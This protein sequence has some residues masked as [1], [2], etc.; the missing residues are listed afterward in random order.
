MIKILRPDNG[1]EFFNSQCTSLLTNFG[2]VH[3]SCCPYTPHQNDIV[4]RKHRHILDTLRALKFQGSIPIRYWGLCVNIAVYLINRLPSTVLRGSTPYELLYHKGASIDH[5]RVLGCLCYETNL[6]KGDK[7]AERERAAVHMGYSE[8]QKGYILLDLHTR[9]F[10]T[11]RDVVFKEFEFPFVKEIIQPQDSGEP[12]FQMHS[13]MHMGT[14]ELKNSTDPSGS[15]ERQT[16]HTATQGNEEHEQVEHDDVQ[17]IFSELVE[18]HDDHRNTPAPAEVQ[19]RCL[20]LDREDC[21]HTN[22][23][24]PVEIQNIC[25]EQSG[26]DKRSNGQTKE[27]I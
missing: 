15:S 16:I 25:T 1:T 27:P 18:Q 2:I 23:P 10:F 13:P 24:E 14:L 22:T 9:Q 5:L 4:E 3:Q 6:I 26:C 21:E 12:I 8:S 17:R 19:N 7:F 20:E 11:S